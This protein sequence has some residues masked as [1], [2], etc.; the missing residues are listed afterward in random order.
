MRIIFL[1]IG[2]ILVMGMCINCGSN[3]S[4][5]IDTIKP[6]SVDSSKHTMGETVL[7]VDEH[8]VNWNVRKFAHY[9]LMLISTIDIFHRV[10]GRMP[11]SLTEF[12]NSDFCFVHPREQET[13]LLFEESDSLDMNHPEYLV[14][15]Y[16]DMDTASLSFSLKTR[17]NEPYFYK[18]QWNRERFWAFFPRDA[19]G[20]DA[21]EWEKREK[22]K[23]PRTSKKAKEMLGQ[24]SGIFRWAVA[25]Y[26]D[27]HSSFPDDFESLFKE[28]WGVF[29]KEPWKNFEYDD[30]GRKLP[31]YVFGFDKTRNVKYVHYIWE[32]S[33]Y[34]YA[35]QLPA[36]FVEEEE[37]PLNRQEITDISSLDIE[38]FADVET[39]RNL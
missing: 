18:Y 28:K 12:F 30:P 19:E 2:L 14:Y 5:D 38:F 29:R 32:N 37:R 26:F 31:N 34:E 33:D 24:F 21:E 4:N 15:E 25:E 36:N 17:L 23:P 16:I 8:P 1:L 3:Q 20:K 27:D 10:N 13:G 39:L 7:Y 9:E 22:T 11:E 35:L 6:D